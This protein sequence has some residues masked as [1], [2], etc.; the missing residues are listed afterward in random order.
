MPIEK[1]LAW[2]AKYFQDVTSEVLV[3]MN[4]KITE[5]WY[6]IL[7]H[8]INEKRQAMKYTVT[9]RRVR[10]TNVVVEKQWVL[11]NTRGGRARAR[12]CVCL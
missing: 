9:F 3:T 7:R 6:V 11:H 5:T 8:L 2:M 4:K 1:I 12:V 10:A